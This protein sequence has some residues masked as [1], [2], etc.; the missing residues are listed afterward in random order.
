MAIPVGRKDSQRR[1]S[2]R[3]LHRYLVPLNGTPPLCA[4]LALKSLLVAFHLCSKGMQWG[5]ETVPSLYYGET[6]SPRGERIHPGSL[7]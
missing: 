1:A 3:L 2:G 4:L 7:K 5:K 6:K